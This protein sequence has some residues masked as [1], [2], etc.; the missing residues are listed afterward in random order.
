MLAVAI[1]ADLRT[2]DIRCLTTAP[3]AEQR[4][5]EAGND[6]LVLRIICLGI[7]AW[8]SNDGA[9]DSIKKIMGEED[10][11]GSGSE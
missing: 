3:T 2:T 7:P 1:S 10:K 9:D 4:W 6:Y 11:D 8:R 5:M